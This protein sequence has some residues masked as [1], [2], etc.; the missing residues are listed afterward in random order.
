M[1]LLSD[2]M[3]YALNTLKNGLILHFDV[4]TVRLSNRRMFS[5]LLFLI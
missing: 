1:Y 2:D 3:G 5:S 4:I